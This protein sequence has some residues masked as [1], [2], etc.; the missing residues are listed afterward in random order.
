MPLDLFVGRANT[1]EKI[2]AL[3][4]TRRVVVSKT[5]AI[6]VLNNS[7]FPFG[8]GIIHVTHIVHINIGLFAG[9]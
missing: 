9:Q 4:P 3:N 6:T 2:K 1:I 8:I 5:A 7:H